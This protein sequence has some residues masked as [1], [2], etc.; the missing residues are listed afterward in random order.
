MILLRFLRLCHSYFARSGIK[1]I[2]GAIM[3]FRALFILLL[4]L[5]ATSNQIFY[6]EI[7]KCPFQ[8]G[9]ECLFTIE[10]G[11]I[12]NDPETSYE[13]FTQGT[14]TGNLSL[15]FLQRNRTH[16]ILYE[17]KFEIICGEFNDT[18]VCL[19]NNPNSFW[20]FNP[21]TRESLL[22]STY[23][24]M[25]IAPDDLQL[26]KYVTIFNYQ[27][28]I[29]ERTGLVFD[30]EERSCYL[31]TYEKESI[32]P[33]GET[34]VFTI[35][36]YF[37]RF[38]G[39]VIEY[40]VTTDTYDQNDILIDSGNYKMILISTSVDLHQGSNF[41]SFSLILFFISLL[42]LIFYLGMRFTST[43]ARVLD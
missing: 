15:A 41:D 21:M 1:G 40:L 12:G 28:Y 17:E 29:S 19:Y 37:D 20:Q 6:H 2:R 24:W 27:F 30:N 13:N 11:W 3:K 5:I 26:G 25:W 35:D 32:L 10:G 42:M 16:L 4:V 39:H 43:N 14:L 18:N 22:L 36:F 23:A 33:K 9:D 7:E 31:V 8:T 38:T 34:R